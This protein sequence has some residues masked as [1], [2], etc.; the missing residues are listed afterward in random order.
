MMTNS[1]GA[2]PLV[3]VGPEYGATWPSGAA[4]SAARDEVGKIVFA[5]DSSSRWSVLKYYVAAATI[6]K[7]QTLGQ[8]P[9]SRNPYSVEAASTTIGGQ[10]LCKGIAAAD[11]NNT[12][13]YFWAYV[14]GYVPD[15]A[16]PTNYAS[17]QPMRLSASYT[18]RLSS[19]AINASTA[20]DGATALIHVIGY[21][22]S[23]GSASTANSTGSFWL[24]GLIV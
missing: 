1:I 21:S 9:G 20:S 15:A 13:Y 5:K 16:M 14:G 8:N 4:D 19:A 3:T 2:P 18:G 11:V 10:N 22:L 24:Q 23:A 7:G 17:N 12:G 6:A